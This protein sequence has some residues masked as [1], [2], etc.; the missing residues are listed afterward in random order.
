MTASTAQATIDLVATAQART[1]V[2]PYCVGNSHALIEAEYSR[3]S[4]RC[5]CGS[6]LAL[7]TN[8]QWVH[9]TGSALCPPYECACGQ[10]H[11]A[12]V[13]SGRDPKAF[14]QARFDAVQA[15][16]ARAYAKS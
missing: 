15:G 16:L 14:D 7:R 5:V 1:I 8:G 9:F 10:R 11:G 4:A 3:V 12:D 2:D 6:T 13:R